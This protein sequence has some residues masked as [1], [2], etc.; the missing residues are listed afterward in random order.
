MNLRRQKSIPIDFSDMDEE[1]SFSDYVIESESTESKSD[2]TSTESQRNKKI[3]KILWK[4]VD[5]FSADFDF[6]FKGAK[7]T[8]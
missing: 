1:S 3:T 7:P 5:Q 2:E 4:P 8:Y 6:S